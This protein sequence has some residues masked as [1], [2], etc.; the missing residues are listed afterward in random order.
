MENTLASILNVEQ[1]TLINADGIFLSPRFAAIMTAKTEEWVLDHV[2]ASED[3]VIVQGVHW[4]R[5]D[6]VTPL[7]MYVAF[8]MP[9]KTMDDSLSK[10]MAKRCLDTFVTIGIKATAH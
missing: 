6:A 9:E 8:D 10:E 3:V 2:E 4:L 1:D 7:L 5:I